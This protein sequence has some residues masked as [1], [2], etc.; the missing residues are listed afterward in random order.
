MAKRRD[1]RT[2]ITL[3]DGM[4]DHPKVEALSDAAFRL[5]VTM[6]CWCSRHL[7]DG[8][9]PATTWAKRGTPRTRQELV[10]AGLA[11]IDGAGIVHMHDYL[12]HQRSADEVRELSAKRAA[13]GSKGGAATAQAKGAANAAPKPK[14]ARSKNAAESV[15]VSEGLLTKPPVG[16]DKP[17]TTTRRTRLPDDFE[18]TPG[19]RLWAAE[20][21]PQVN[22]DRET[23]K[24]KDHHVAAGN[25]MA[26]WSR[27]WQKWMRTAD[28]FRASRGNRPGQQSETD[29]FF[30]RAM[31]RAQA[32]DA[33][34]A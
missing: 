15:S 24:F 4:P 26:D 19:M 29:D 31:A 34:G 14:Q 33:E 25:T 6:W 5:L 13:A 1:T 8:A 20:N 21:I 2:Y 27:A 11:E 32:K 22:V 10:S 7:T 23:E 30:A 12:E 9:V 3:H 17:T 18:V 28:D 16:S